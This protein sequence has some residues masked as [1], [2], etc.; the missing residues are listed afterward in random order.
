MLEDF[1][2]RYPEYQDFPDMEYIDP[3]AVQV[4]LATYHKSL[5]MLW[6][7]FPPVSTRSVLK[8]WIRL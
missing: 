8:T 7:T 1:L 3:A 2:S 4:L 6:P 5:R